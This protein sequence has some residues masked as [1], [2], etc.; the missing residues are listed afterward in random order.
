[1]T[2]DHRSAVDATVDTDPHT[3]VA[4]LT[5]QRDLTEAIA[6]H[7]VRLSGDRATVRRLLAGI[8]MPAPR[9]PHRRP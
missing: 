7:G 6:A 2:A 3:F 8:S 4:L 9:K 1:V 5:G